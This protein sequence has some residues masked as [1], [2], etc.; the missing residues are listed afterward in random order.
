[1][2]RAGPS[3]GSLG[4]AGKKVQARHFFGVMGPPATDKDGII[5]TYRGG[6]AGGDREGPIRAIANGE[7]TA[8]LG[9]PV[10]ERIDA[11]ATRRKRPHRK[12]L[13]AAG[14]EQGTRGTP[15]SPC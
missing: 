2:V 9:E 12:I 13:T 15:S 3:D 1:M 10:Y 8:Q 5:R 6:D 7:L 4:L 11:P 14:P